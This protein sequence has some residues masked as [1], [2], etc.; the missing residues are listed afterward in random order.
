M[1]V[2]TPIIQIATLTVLHAGQSLPFGGTVALQFIRDDHARHISEALEQLAQE[3]LRGLFIA[4]AL[5]QDIEDVI[6]LVDSAPEVMAFA[7]DGQKHLVGSSALNRGYDAHH[8]AIKRCNAPEGRPRR[9]GGVQRGGGTGNDSSSRIVQQWS[10]ISAA[11]AG[12]VF[13]T[14]LRLS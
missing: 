8:R 7:V 4:P 2:L 14:E 1:R 12:V 3:L 13:W 6:V 11:M 10:V 9:L 5:Y